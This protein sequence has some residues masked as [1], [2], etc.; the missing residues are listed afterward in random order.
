[1]TLKAWKTLRA[2]AAAAPTVKFTPSAVAALM[3]MSSPASA[4]DNT[5]VPMRRL[6]LID[7]EG[8]LTERGNKWRVD[9]TY[10]DACQEILDDVYP[11]ELLSLTGSDG[12]VDAARVRT[13]FDHK[14][15][16]DSNARQMAATYTMIASKRPPEAA[17][18]QARAVPPKK[19]AV[20]K[21]DAPPRRAASTGEAP[22]PSPLAVEPKPP[23]PNVHLDIQIHIPA[24][25]S[26]EQIDQIL[27][28]WRSTS[29]GSDH[30]RRSTCQC[31]A[32]TPTVE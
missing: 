16:G 3:G 13:W 21:R 19:T 12:M 25:A 11:H 9:A 23:G 10:G 14:G 8:A 17:P 31:E 5:V 30:P 2:R 27:R 26:P 32:R 1:V 28:A 24:D 29:T 7:D 6:G 18:P 15:F 4:R 20:S 22:A